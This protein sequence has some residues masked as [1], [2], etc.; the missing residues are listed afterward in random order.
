MK[1][2]PVPVATSE[3]AK[4]TKVVVEQKENKKENSSNAVAI[5]TQNIVPIQESKPYEEYYN[6]TRR[7]VKE[8]MWHKFMNSKVVRAIKYAFKIRIRLQLPEGLP[9][10]DVQSNKQ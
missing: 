2:I 4:E 8:S 6:E 5:N 7:E 1:L 9:D 3:S 10:G